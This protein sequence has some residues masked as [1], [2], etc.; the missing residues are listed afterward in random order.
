MRSCDYCGKKN[1]D[2]AGSCAGCGCS[3]N[4]P[5]VSLSIPWTPLL[6]W[7][8]FAFSLIMNASIVYGC[9]P[10]FFR[11]E[12]LSAESMFWFIIL[13]LVA[14]LTFIIGMPCAILAIMKGRRRIGWLGIIIALTPA[15]LGLI[16]METAMHLNGLH[17]D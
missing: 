8:G 13:A 1:E 10:V 4:E 9:L 15:P 12:N 17:Y 6:S 2:T 16:L 7:G 5:K 11:H 3:L 14:I